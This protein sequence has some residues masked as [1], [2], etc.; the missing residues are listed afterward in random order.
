MWV[1]YMVRIWSTKEH[2]YWGARG[3]GYTDNITEAGAFEKD[4]AESNIKLIEMIT[5][6]EKL[7]M[8]EIYE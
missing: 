4:I 6:D 3:E 8:E 7:L 2:K 5:S 1:K